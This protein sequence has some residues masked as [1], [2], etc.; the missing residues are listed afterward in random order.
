MS[1]MKMR[2]IVKASRM[3]DEADAIYSAYVHEWGWIDTW[4]AHI[5]DR[6]EAAIRE[7]IA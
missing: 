6:C 3:H 2:W 7:V 4:P 1:L 5:L